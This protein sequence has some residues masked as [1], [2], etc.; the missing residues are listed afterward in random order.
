MYDLHLSPEELE[1]L[2]RENVYLEIENFNPQM[3][4]TIQDTI[5]ESSPAKVHVPMSKK[6]KLDFPSKAL[7]GEVSAVAISLCKGNKFVNVNDPITVVRNNKSVQT[8]RNW[9]P[10]KLNNECVVRLKNTRT[11][12]EFAR[13]T[14]E[15]SSFISTLLDLEMC[16]IGAELIYV[17]DNLK[18][19]DEIVVSVKIYMN[20]MAF[21]LKLGNDLDINDQVWKRKKALAFLF[22]RTGLIAMNESLESKSSQLLQNIDPDKITSNELANIYSKA[23]QI[24]KII[25]MATP[26]DQ[27]KLKLQD[28]QKV[29]LAFMLSKENRT[30]DTSTISPLWMEMKTIDGYKF[31][32]SPYSG[33]LSLEYPVEFH[34]QGGILADE[35]VFLL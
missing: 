9:T 2:S 20:K 27:F 15:T 17:P 1:W 13:L 28:Y 5:S 7:I 4:S 25:E 14:K 29:G 31:Y 8:K 19:S 24:D 23:N 16:S 34:C 30:L 33:E 10:K 35:M 26:P 32:Y 22:Q 3:N 21:D 12:S 18:I 6:P 11:M